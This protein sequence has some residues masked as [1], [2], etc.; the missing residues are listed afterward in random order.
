[1]NYTIIAMSYVIIFSVAMNDK[2][3]QKKPS[4]CS[5]IL[6]CETG[7]GKSSLINALLPVST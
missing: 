5:T 2:G 3:Q 7:S 1:M 6:T 4:T